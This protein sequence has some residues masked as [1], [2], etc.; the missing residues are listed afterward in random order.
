MG[1]GGLLGF[2]LLGVESGWLRHVCLEIVCI[3]IYYNNSKI[4]F[5]ALYSTHQQR[6]PIVLSI[7]IY[8]RIL[9]SESMR[10]L[11]NQVCLSSMLYI[12]GP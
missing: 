2:D 9:R 4:R 8:L 3:N 7:Y 6:Q 12:L 11:T 5:A 1:A 10:V